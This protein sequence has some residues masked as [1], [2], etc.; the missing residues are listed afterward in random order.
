[1]QDYFVHEK[2]MILFITSKT[3]FFFFTTVEDNSKN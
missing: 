2:K 1:M 3:K